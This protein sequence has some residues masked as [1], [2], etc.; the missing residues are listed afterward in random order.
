M[1]CA[2]CSATDT[3]AYTVL[4]ERSPPD[5]VA[6]CEACI[7]DA[8]HAGPLDAARLGR[9]R[10]AIWSEDTRIQV[11]AW[12]CLRRLPEHGWAT[13][14]LDQVWLDAEL[15]AWAEAGLP[16]AN[17]TDAPAAPTLDSNGT[18]LTE[19]DA[20]TLIKDLD[21]KGAGFTAKRGTLVKSIHLTDDPGL[22]EGRV[23]G[24]VIVLKTGFLKRA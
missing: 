1:S 2:L 22:V 15:S 17:D 16:A 6:L 14:L 9:L 21:V 12:R 3:G 23:N 8:S 20:V 4:P 5:I 10:D 19:G 24:M 11:L 13:D 18:P 7:H